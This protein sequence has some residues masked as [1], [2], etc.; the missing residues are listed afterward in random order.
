MEQRRVQ[1]IDFGIS[2]YRP[3]WQLQ[4]RIVAKKLKSVTPDFLLLGEHLPVYTLGK[5]A[6]NANILKKESFLEQMSIPVYRVE[7]G[8]DVTWHGP[9]Q[10]VCYPLF[11]LKEQGLDLDRFVDLLEEAVIETLKAFELEGAREAGMRGVWVKR[12]KIASIGLAV[13]GWVTYHGLAIN[14]S[15]DLSFFDWIIPCGIK[16]VKMCSISAMK[17]EPVSV[18]K[19]KAVFLEVMSRLFHLEICPVNAKDGN[20]I[21]N[22]GSNLLLTVL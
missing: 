1:C 19:V 10:M 4:K 7:R 15:P 11:G 18:A 6:D 13:K 9:G 17:K 3:L 2:P 16:N 12:M 8:G 22:N 20:K 14:V 5:R 21:N